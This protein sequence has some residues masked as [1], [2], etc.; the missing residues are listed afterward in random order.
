M[1]NKKVKLLP[2]KLRLIGRMCEEAGAQVVLSAIRREHADHR[3][4]LLQAL[5]EVADVSP[6][7]LLGQTGP[8]IAVHFCF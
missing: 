5:V 2:D 6:H 8:A 7:K 3:D 1:N 4:E